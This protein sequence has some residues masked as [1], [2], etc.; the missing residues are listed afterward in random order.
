MDVLEG[1]QGGAAEE[2][3]H[4]VAV[5]LPLALV[6]RPG[7]DE[8]APGLVGGTGEVLDLGSLEWLQ[9][10]LD[11]Q[12]MELVL[13]CERPEHLHSRQ[14]VHVD[15]AD[16]RPLRPMTVQEFRE[17]ADLAALDPFRRVVDAG[18]RDLARTARKV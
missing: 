11:R 13:L 8:Q 3:A 15:P 2:H 7:D 14:A 17:V 16:A 18:D 9:H 4:L 12:R 6:D 5:Q 10:V 1:E